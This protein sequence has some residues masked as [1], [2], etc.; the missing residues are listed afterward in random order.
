MELWR[1]QKC[2]K[3]STLKYAK[4]IGGVKFGIVTGRLGYL[5]SNRSMQTFGDGGLVATTACSSSD[6]T[7]RRENYKVRGDRKSYPT[8]LLACRVKTLENAYCTYL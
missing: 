7:N 2:G 6:T 1:G 8:R 5:D 3:F 4:L